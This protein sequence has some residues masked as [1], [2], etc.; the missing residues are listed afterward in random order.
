MISVLRF[1]PTGRVA[2]LYTEAVELRSL[3]RLEVTRAADLRFNEE[4][5]E[6]QVHAIG[7]DAV[8]HADPSRD[9]C[10]IWERG[11]LA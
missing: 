7:D 9:A 11:H 1:D 3:G 2:C 4:T 5:Q 10:L 6:W 8:L